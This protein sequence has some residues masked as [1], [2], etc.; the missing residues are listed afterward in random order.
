MLFYRAQ[1]ALTWFSQSYSWTDK[2]QRWVLADGLTRALGQKA[3]WF[4]LTADLS[5]GALEF[6]SHSSGSMLFPTYHCCLLIIALWNKINFQVHLT[7]TPK[8][9]AQKTESWTTWDSR[10]RFKWLLSCVVTVSSLH[11]RKVN[12][13]MSLPPFPLEWRKASSG[14]S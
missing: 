12:G 8:Q 4:S 3:Q 7:W 2:H 13:E 11:Y 5:S 14:V 10:H 1:D 6:P 9:K